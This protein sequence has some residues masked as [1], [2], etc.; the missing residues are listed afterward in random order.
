VRRLNS[1]PELEALRKSILDKRDP[2]KP[3]VALC[4]GTGCLAYGC[5]DILSALK[6]EVA[7]QG[8]RIRSTSGPPVAPASAREARS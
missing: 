1:A 8:L 5:M 3:C 6:N 4:V 7:R 2:Q